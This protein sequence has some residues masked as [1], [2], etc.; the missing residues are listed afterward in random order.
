MKKNRLLK[1]ILLSASMVAMFASCDKSLENINV[2][3]NGATDAPLKAVFIG[4]M[5]GVIQP[6]SGENA[7]LA[8]L[9]SQQFTGSDRQYAGF[10]KYNINAEDFDWV[11]YYYAVVQQANIVI[12]KS[13]A[14]DN[15][16]YSGVAKIA[17]AQSFGTLT[18]LWGNVPFYQAADIENYKAPAFDPQSTVY[19]EVQKL[20]SDGIKDLE[21]AGTDV[22]NADFYFKGNKASWIKVAH[23]LKARYYLHVR[24][25]AAALAETKLGV[26]A[27]AEE[28]KIPHTS[29]AYNQDMNIYYSF[30]NR[31]RV[32]YMTANDAYLPAILDTTPANVGKRNHAKTTENQRFAHIYKGAKGSYDLN[33]AGMWTAKSSFPLV[34]VEENLLIAAECE[35]QGGSN[36]NGLTEL[37]KVRTI[38]AG[39]YPKGKYTAFV[40]SDFDASGIEDNGK[41]N[42]KDNLLYEILEEKYT[43]LVGQIEV[44]NDLRRTKNFMGLTP[45]SGS[46]IPHRFLIPQDEINANASAPSPIPG[47]FVKTPINQ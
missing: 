31:D 10:E 22:F 45:R 33:Y 5:V 2:N 8:C 4:A 34:T 47:L 36:A 40:L 38:L 14:I 18:S 23:T 3:Q 11:G 21:G 29:G 6:Q 43:S 25:Y 26:S 7:R 44:Y 16:F 32:G 41:G 20:L 28:W 35:V 17:K 37:N 46:E 1:N 15:G 27:S 19:D 42:Q 30:G 13:N 12:T 39:K 24:N 9:W